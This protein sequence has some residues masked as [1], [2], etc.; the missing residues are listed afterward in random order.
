MKRNDNMKTKEQEIFK[1][2]AK[3]GYT[4]C[5][6]AQCPLREHCLRYL[7]GQQM[8]DTRS[9]YYCVNPHYQ[10]VGTEQCPLFRQSE[11]VMFAKGMLSTFNND[12]PRKVEPFVRENLIRMHC[13]T[14][15][16][17]Y[18]NGKRLIPPAVQEEIRCLFRKAG[19]TQEIHF[20][21][22]VE[23]YDW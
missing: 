16:F 4:V 6:A 20:D 11:K 15:Y 17:E 3:D 5:F 13:R 18:R 2:K 12:M 22:Y 1:E 7:V 10:G 9:C 19:W 14:Y 8:P 23:D 21:G